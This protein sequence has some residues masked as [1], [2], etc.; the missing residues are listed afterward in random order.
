MLNL[1]T[2]NNK[3][4]TKDNPTS[5]TCIPYIQ[6]VT[7]KIAKILNKKNIKTAF[8]PLSTIKQR[9][10][11][12]KDNQE[13]LQ[14][15]GVYIIKC[16][17]G[18]Q[19]IGETGRSVRIRLK[20]HSA[21]IRNERTKSSALAEHVGKTNHHICLEDT[22]VIANVEHQFKRKV[23]EAIEIIKHPKNLN[24]DGVMEISKNWNPVLTPANNLNNDIRNS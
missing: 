17:C 13:H 16:S 14:Q 3:N 10:R 11:S 23:R 15:K 22:K 8:K 20:E 7:D 18:D 12:V 6:G 21:D 19:Y 4:K 5:N 24:R 2:D 9:M 1:K